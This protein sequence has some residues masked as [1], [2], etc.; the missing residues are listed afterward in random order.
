[1]PDFDD[2]MRNSAA[3]VDAEALF[4]VWWELSI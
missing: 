3:A 4:F 1:M 2:D